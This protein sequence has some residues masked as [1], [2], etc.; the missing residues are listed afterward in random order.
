MTTLPARSVVFSAI[1]PTGIFHLGNYLGAIQNWHLLS[2]ENPESTFYFATAD[3]HAITMPKDA[4]LLRQ[5][6]KQAIASIIASG[7]D[8]KTKNVTLFHQSSVPEH[9]ELCW[10]LGT[11]TGMGHLNRMTQWKSKLNLSQSVNIDNNKVLSSLKLGLFSYP[12]LQAAD[13]ILYKAT[14]VPVGEDQSQHLE[15]SRHLA[16]K[17]NTTFCEKDKPIFPIPST[18][19]T[20]TR[21]VLSLRDPN[22][23]MS[24][25][26]P[27]PNSKIFIT[28]SP[29]V[30]RTK[31]SKAITDSIPGAITFSRTERPG[32]A[33][34][35]AIVAGLRQ[36]TPEEVVESLPSS[37]TNHKEFKSYVSDEIIAGLEK[38]RN[39]FER[40]IKEPQYLEAVAKEGSDS[41][42]NIAQDVMI[43]VKRA[44]GFL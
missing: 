30:I 13:I 38:P 29:D 40:I 15:L 31:I 1:Q 10:I 36:T 19:L 27:D 43:E 22:K 39:E 6:R 2:S 21:K 23:K 25:S 17:F 26:D 32:I 41:A 18:L 5:Y 34:L 9:A 11:Q 37:I 8:P 4:D 3:L 44:V 7:I 42:R 14:H 12:V 16:N 28:D 20:P 24:K 35:L 33:N